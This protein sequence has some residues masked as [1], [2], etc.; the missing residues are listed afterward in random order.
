MASLRTILPSEYSAWS[1]IKSRCRN[2]NTSGFKYYGARGIDIC[3][4]WFDSF[5]AF[6][7][8]VGPK[9]SPDHTIDR[10]NNDGNYEPGNCRWATMKE[11]CNNRRRRASLK[12]KPRKERRSGIGSGGR[13]AFKVRS[14]PQKHAGRHTVLKIGRIEAAIWQWSIITGIAVNTIVYRLRTGWTA[15]DA[16]ATK[17]QRTWNKGIRKKIA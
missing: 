2:P 5:Q 1:N 13:M 12:G 8:H 15:E 11:Q 3:Q 14:V 6:I 10:I 17:P 7:D 4:D 9:P 16:I